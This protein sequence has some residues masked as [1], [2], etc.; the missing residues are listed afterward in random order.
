MFIKWGGNVEN[1]DS[2]DVL[3]ERYQKLLKWNHRIIEVG[4][5]L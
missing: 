2:K 4:K 1:R 3:K 5:D